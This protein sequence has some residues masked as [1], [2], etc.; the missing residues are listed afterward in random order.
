MRDPKKSKALVPSN[1]SFSAEVNVLFSV[2]SLPGDCSPTDL[3]HTS[4]RKRVIAPKNN[5]VDTNLFD[6]ELQSILIMNKRVCPEP[7]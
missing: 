3:V 6:Q 1:C 5:S 4:T 7:A 2:I